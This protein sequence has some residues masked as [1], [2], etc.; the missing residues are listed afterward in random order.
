MCVSVFDDE[1]LAHRGREQCNRLCTCTDIGFDFDSF[2]TC[3]A[4]HCTVHTSRSASSCW[5]CHRHLRRHNCSNART[6]STQKKWISIKTFAIYRI[7][8][9]RISVS[10]SL[11]FNVIF[12]SLKTIWIDTS[13]RVFSLSIFRWCIR[14]SCEPMCVWLNNFRFVFAFYAP[15]TINGVVYA[16]DGVQIG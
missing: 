6:A 1:P 4:S 11:S 8:N 10:S 13:E 16:V 9:N 15:D 5:R 2:P 3:R 12:I 7:A 14:L